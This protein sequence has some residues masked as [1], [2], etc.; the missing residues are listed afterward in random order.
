M[1]ATARAALSV[2]AARRQLSKLRVSPAGS[3]AGYSR[4]EFPHWS[5]AKE[6]STGCRRPNAQNAASD[7]LAESLSA[8]CDKITSDR[9]C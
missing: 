2:D 8:M 9:R 5:D 7:D 6:F 4:E 1:R 3:M